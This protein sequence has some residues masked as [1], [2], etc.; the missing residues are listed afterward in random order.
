MDGQP[1]AM[2]TDPPFSG[3]GIASDQKVHFRVLSCAKGNF[4]SANGR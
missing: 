1:V 3:R 2:T 4:R